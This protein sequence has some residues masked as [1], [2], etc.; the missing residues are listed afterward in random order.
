MGCKMARG[1]VGVAHRLTSVQWIATT[2]ITGALCTSATDIL[3]VHADL[4]PIEILLHRICHRVALPE[5]HLLHK[6]IKMM[7]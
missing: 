5:T 3:E 7:A 1:S 6:T 2:A 4:W